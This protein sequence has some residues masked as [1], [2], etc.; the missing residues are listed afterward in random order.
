MIKSQSDGLEKLSPKYDYLFDLMDTLEPLRPRTFLKMIDGNTISHIL[1]L[2]SCVQTIIRWKRVFAFMIPGFQHQ[3]ALLERLYRVICSILF[4]ECD[5]VHKSPRKGRAVMIIAF[6]I[7][8]IKHL[9]QRQK[10]NPSVVDHLQLA[11]QN[12]LKVFCH[13]FFDFDGSKKIDD[14]REWDALKVAMMVERVH[15]LSWCLPPRY[16][17]CSPS[18]WDTRL[19]NFLTELPPV[20]P[21][22]LPACL[23]RRFDSSVYCYDNSDIGVCRCG[24]TFDSIPC[25]F[26]EFFGYSAR[27]FARFI[28]SG[29][30]ENTRQT[31]NAVL[32]GPWTEDIGLRKVMVVFRVILSFWLRQ[33]FRVINQVIGHSEID[34][35]TIDHMAKNFR[36][37]VLAHILRSTVSMYHDFWKSEEEANIDIYKTYINILW[38]AW[39]TDGTEDFRSSLVE[40]L[41]ESNQEAELSVSDDTDMSSNKDGTSDGLENGSIE[42]EDSVSDDTDMFS[43]EHSTSNEF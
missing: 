26:L 30:Q 8:E 23:L 21:L 9:A 12:R 4:R 16:H 18:L 14:S 33:T 42:V 36:P 25:G 5:I 41:A 27:S 39:G 20:T 31:L 11:L 22:D 2:C 7:D 10:L 35:T 32:R 29:P 3:L 24:W 13:R 43:D 15:G 1:W 19:L 37:Q 38:W 28:H 34:I 6:T 40:I 17:G